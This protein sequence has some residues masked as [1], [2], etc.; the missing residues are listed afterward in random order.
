M[1]SRQI[2]IIIILQFSSNV[3]I[4]FSFQ[5]VFVSGGNFSF[6]NLNKMTAPTT[7]AA[8]TS[9]ATAPTTKFNFELISAV[10]PSSLPPTIGSETFSF[11]LQPKSPSKGKSP[12]KQHTNSTGVEDVSD[13]ENVEEEENQTYFTPVIPLPNKID[14]KTGEEDEQ[15]LYSHRAKLFRYRDSEWRE[16]GL[17]DVK[18]LQHQ[19]TGRLRYVFATIT[20]KLY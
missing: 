20:A 15:V 10:A 16:R 13:D 14:V 3:T 8:P 18:I 12:L 11:V 2:Y 4:H 5:F 19:S 6:G 9:T 7:N 17:G 1:T